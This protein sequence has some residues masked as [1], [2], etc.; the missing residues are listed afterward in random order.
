MHH[1]SHVLPAFIF[2]DLQFSDRHTPTARKTE[3]CLG[4]ATISIEGTIG[5]WPLDD[6]FAVGLTARQTGHKDRQATGR[7]LHLD[8]VMVQAQLGEQGGH[9][10]AQLCDGGGEVSGR[11][12]L[13]ANF[14]HK[15]LWLS[16]YTG[17]LTL[18]AVSAA[19]SARQRASAREREWLASRCAVVSR[20]PLPEGMVQQRIVELLALRHIEHR[21]IPRHVAHAAEVVGAFSDANGPTRVQHVE[22]V[23]TFQVIVVGRQ[24]KLGV[25]TAP[26]LA[27]VG[28]VHGP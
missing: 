21:D 19:S 6:R 1:R 11:E 8:R 12:L 4:G 18:F 22:Q 10:R 7:P 17:A 3:R 24:D 16:A 14:E 2:H 25:Q 13:A 23:R 9:G 27:L 5:R 26:G 28:I 20:V 15:G